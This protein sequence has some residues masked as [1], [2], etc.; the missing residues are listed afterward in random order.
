MLNNDKV[1]Y[2]IIFANRIQSTNLY[3]FYEVYK[4]EGILKMLRSRLLTYFTCCGH[5]SNLSM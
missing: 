5:L 3:I 2:I 4:Y 1:Y